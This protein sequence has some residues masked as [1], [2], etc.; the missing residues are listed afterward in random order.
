MKRFLTLLA[1]VG[2]SG[3]TQATYSPKKGITYK[4]FIFQKQFDEV[5]IS[6]NGTFTIKGYRSEAATLVKAVSEGVAT[7]LTKGA[8]VP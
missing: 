2:L 7:G 3:C 5:S 6:T 1:V 8:G 4:N